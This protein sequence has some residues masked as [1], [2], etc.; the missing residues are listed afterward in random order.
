MHSLRGCRPPRHF[1]LGNSV[2]TARK[3]SAP[4]R[5]RRVFALALAICLQFRA[6]GKP[7]D[8]DDDRKPL[9]ETAPTFSPAGTLVLDA[10]TGKP[11]VG[12][13]PVDL[14]RSPDS[15][16]PD[17]KG[18]YLVAVNS[19]YG[20]QFDARTSR[21]QQSLALIDLNAKPAPAVVQNVYFPSPQSACVGAVFSPPAADGS[22]TLFVSG[23][24][25]NKVWGFRYRPGAP[26]PLTPGSPGPKSTVT[27]RSVDV[28]ALAPEPPTPRY[29]AGQAAVYPL[30]LAM[31]GGDLL[32]ANDLDDSLSLIRGFPTDHPGGAE[33]S[34]D[35]F[36][37]RRV[38]LRRRADE[39]LYPYA[40]ATCPDPAPAS[41]EPSAKAYVS[42][43]NASAVAVVRFHGLDA[44]PPT[45]VP[46]GSHP[47][48]LLMDDAR[49]R[50]YVA[51]SDDDS[52]SVLDTVGDRE[53][54]RINVRLTEQS[55]PGVSPEALALS[56][57]GGTL[58]VAAAHANTVA[59]VRLGN[60]ARAEHVPPGATAAPSR[61]AGL[62][63]AGRYPSAL[64]VVGN[65][66][67]VGNGKGTGTENSSNRANLSGRNPNAPNRDFPPGD[68][69]PHAG[70]GGAYS[71]SVV[72]GNLLA[73]P[74]PDDATLARFTA[75]A[76][77]ENGLTDEKKA[78][79]FAGRA[80]G[81][82]IKHVI[83]V[84]KENRTYDQVFGDVKASGDGT[85]ADG[86]PSLAIFGAGEAARG[87]GGVAQDVA[88]N[89]RALAQRFG[90]LDRFFVNSEASADGHNWSTA[91][92]STDYVDKVFRWNYSRRG[93]SYDFEGFNRLPDTGQTGGE[94][95]FPPD[96]TADTI[97]GF[98]RKYLPYTHDDKDVGEPATLYLWDLAARGGLSYRNYGEF[99][100]T[101]SADDLAAA[102]TGKRKNY[103]DVSPTVVAVPAKA[104]LDGHYS[105]SAR[106]FDLD[107][108]DA[109][110]VDSYRAAADATAPAGAVDPLIR[111][112]NPAANCRGVSRL[113]AWLEEFAGVQA[114]FAA[115]KPDPLP[116]L[117]ILRLSNDHTA[118]LAPGKP[119]PQFYMAD[120]DYALGRLVEAVSRSAYWKNTAVVAVEDDAQDGPDH[121]DCHRSVA[122]V[123]SAYNRPGALVHGYRTTAGLIRTMELLLG[124]PP[125][126]TQDATAIPID[127]F[128]DGPP[129]LRPYVAALPRLDA[130]KLVTP[131]AEDAAN[132]DV[133]QA[134]RRSAT[135]DLEHADADD[136]SV[137][138]ALIWLSVRGAGSTPPGPRHLPAY[139]LLRAGR[140]HAADDD[141]D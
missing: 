11:A 45:F 21:G 48:A 30:G 38:D 27:A 126:N 132:P 111:A 7:A 63:P 141:D 87:P 97:A 107:T 120:N 101:A 96:V 31:S 124:L 122:L 37:I 2:V 71:V 74:L 4:W 137:L 69:G 130:S 18:R 108:P 102:R 110:T 90:L 82:P 91:A 40:V 123:V 77:R 135:L 19:G 10:A 44:S 12:S 64:A 99:V 136:P 125:M 41:A 70:R 28:G 52:V 61:L 68:R 8:D 60:A 23:G 127:V 134:I 46:T 6:N 84:I 89:H 88:P 56:G 43:W 24:F 32:A 115:G 33:A 50:L 73:I 34:P 121:V 118:G 92:F 5:W 109:F 78:T 119:S 140:T 58:F 103:P 67:Y 36:A 47:T 13:L 129:D 39:N 72:S 93:R 113:G 59:V 14:V 106:N 116:A 94:P 104:S 79:L 98:L 81:S 16:G 80:G 114:D 57:D 112:D 139:D 42:L 105:A 54:E 3:P 138:N 29:N 83:Y 117:S 133:A 49:H 95:F 22:A 128:G 53:I 131:R 75:Q 9:A 17:G 35:L 25:E 85:P 15:L 1:I 51:N 62:L 86:D 20:V 66:L 26:Q 100:A 76:L 65:T 55:L